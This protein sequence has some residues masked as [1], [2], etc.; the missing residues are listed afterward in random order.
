[1]FTGTP[2]QLRAAKDRAAVIAGQ[3]AELPNQL[4][5]VHPESTHGRVLF[6]G[7]EIRARRGRWTVH[8]G[9]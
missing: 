6:L 2:E 8:T 9:R 7:G 1:M 4:D 3:V 5:A